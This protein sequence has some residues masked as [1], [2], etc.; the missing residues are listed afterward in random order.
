MGMQTRGFWFL[1]AM[2]WVALLGVLPNHLKGQFLPGATAYDF[3]RLPTSAHVA[4]VG[5]RG[6]SIRGQDGAWA[7]QNPALLNDSMA[8]R[9]QTSVATYVAAIGMGNL[10][11]AGRLL[12]RDKTFVA[13]WHAGTQFVSYGRFTQTDEF[14]NVQ[15]NFIAADVALYA[16]LA[17]SFG[18]FSY[19]A[20]LKLVSSTLASYTSWGLGLDFGALYH[21]EKIQLTVGASLRNV[22]AQ[23]TPY[24]PG[25]PRLPLPTELEAGITHKLR[26]A[27]FRLS[28][29]TSNLLTLPALST[30]TDNTPPTTWDNLARRFTFGAEILLHRAFD[31]RGGY[32]LQRRAEQA[33]QGQAFAL[34][35]L[36][37]GFGLRI[38]AFAV[39]YAY[40]QLH[41]A[42]ALNQFTLAYRP[43]VWR[44]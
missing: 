41:A 33:T 14:G 8:G 10:N 31:V 19:G 1:G 26:R 12:R 6:V 27:P 25:G 11:Y 34:T 22:G 32:N 35:G 29:T 36:T 5:G 2:A 15:G 3:L 30:Q 4:A 38:H 37:L 24:A 28:L 21:H 18:R 39:D 44:Q 43:A 16:G 20:N 13:Y 17:R 42:G 7:W 40:S 9:I 23:L